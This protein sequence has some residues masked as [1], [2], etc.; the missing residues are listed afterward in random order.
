MKPQTLKRMLALVLAGLF[1]VTWPVTLGA[2]DAGSLLFSEPRITALLEDAAL[3]SKLVPLGLSWY[4]HTVASRYPPD[5]YSTPDYLGI[6]SH[7]TTQD[8]VTLRQIG[9][10]DAMLVDW[11]DTT[12]AGVYGWLDNDEV[13]PEVLWAMRHFQQ[14]LQEGNGEKALKVVYA[15]L[16]ACEPEQVADFLHRLSEVPPETDIPYNPCHFP[17]QWESDQ[18]NDYLTSVEAM[19]AAIPP[20]LDLVQTLAPNTPDEDFLTLKKH[21]LL[22]RAVSRW[23]W[24]LSLAFLALAAAVQVRTWLAL[25]HWW[26]VPLALGGLLTLGLYFATPRVVLRWLAS[27]LTA[28]PEELAAETMTFLMRVVHLMIQPMVWQGVVSLGL[29]LAGLLAFAKYRR[30]MNV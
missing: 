15:S 28:W 20:H 21:L 26:G 9:I 4:A 24:L 8:W 22:A 27:L 23:G 12:T 25:A 30:R 11:T 6:M 14:H 7:L 5:P 10:T 19:I 29:G 16:P 17:V 18:Y 2:Y 13:K 1:V 3:H